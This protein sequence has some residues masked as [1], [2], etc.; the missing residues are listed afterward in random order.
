[1]SSLFLPQIKDSESLILLF[2]NTESFL[3]LFQ[4]R[5]HQR[6]DMNDILRKSEIKIK[7]TGSDSASESKKNERITSDAFS[8]FVART[9][10]KVMPVSCHWWFSIHIFFV[11]EKPSTLPL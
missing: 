6:I 10:Q 1:M 3:S 9:V 11:A 4:L 7:K 5:C 2:S 8:V